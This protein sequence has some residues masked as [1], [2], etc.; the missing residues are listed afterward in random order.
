MTLRRLKLCRNP[1]CHTA[2]YDLS[3]NNSK[4]WHDLATCGSPQHIANTVLVSAA[5]SPLLTSG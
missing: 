3:K 4:V 1:L 5:S 2:F